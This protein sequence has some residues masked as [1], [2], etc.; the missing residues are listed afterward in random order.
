MPMIFLEIDIWSVGVIMLSILSKKFPFF[1]STDD[2]EALLEIAYIFGKKRMQRLAA[3]HRIPL[4][5]NAH[6][7]GRTFETNIF[8][9]PDDIP[10]LLAELNP[11]VI[12]TFEPTVFDLLLACL[13][14]HPVSRISADTAYNHVFLDY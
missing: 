8:T 11:S 13:D 4:K 6:F 14:L 2:S 10:E 1:H 7:V 12:D 9:I 5:N 3:Y